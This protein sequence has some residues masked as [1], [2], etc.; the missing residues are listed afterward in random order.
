MSAVLK[1][2]TIVFRPMSE[3]DLEYVMEI[4]KGVYEFP[5]SIGIFQDVQQRVKRRALKKTGRA[6]PLLDVLEN[7]STA[8]C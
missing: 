1:Q 7:Y 3:M 5:W 4:E 2:A 6:N 8:C